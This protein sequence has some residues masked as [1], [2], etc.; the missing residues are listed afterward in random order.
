MRKKCG[1]VLRIGGFKN[2]NLARLPIPPRGLYT[3]TSGDNAKFDN[4]AEWEA[5]GKSFKKGL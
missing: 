1:V 5:K 4:D 3:L 2:L